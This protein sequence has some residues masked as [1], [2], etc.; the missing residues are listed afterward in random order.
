MLKSAVMI[1]SQRPE[2]AGKQSGCAG[3][4]GEGKTKRRTCSVLPRV[5]LHADHS[6]DRLGVHLVV[7]LCLIVAFTTCV[8]PVAAGRHHLAL[9]LVVS[10][11]QLTAAHTA[12]YS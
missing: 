7:G 4:G 8:R 5:A 3:V 10:A 6:I 2:D 9:P 11:A 1:N 12:T